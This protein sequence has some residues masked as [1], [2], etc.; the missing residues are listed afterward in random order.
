MGV[1]MI[2]GVVSTDLLLLGMHGFSSRD[3]FMRLLWFIAFL[4][5]MEQLVII[6][7]ERFKYLRIHNVHYGGDTFISRNR[8]KLFFSLIVR[9]DSALA[10]NTSNRGN[11]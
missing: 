2:C 5:V 7:N 11:Q 3:G 10:D 9:L 1:M 6:L 8:V 4:M